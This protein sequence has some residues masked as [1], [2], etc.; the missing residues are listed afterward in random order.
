MS[1]ASIHALLRRGGVLQG[2][3]LIAAILVGVLLIF[4]LS[5]PSPAAADYKNPVGH[6]QPVHDLGGK[7]IVQEATTSQIREKDADTVSDKFFN[8]LGHHR[9]P[10]APETTEAAIIEAPP[11]PV[12]SIPLE[13][14]S[15]SL[16]DPVCA[17]FSKGTKDLLVVIKTPASELYNQLPT[18]F[19]T[20]LRCAPM[21]LWSYVSHKIGS[22]VIHD[23]LANV[24]VK[25]RQAN[26][27]FDLYHRLQTAQNAF[28]DFSTI[29]EDTDHNLDR[30]SIIPS[31]V[32]SYRMNPEKKWFVYIEGDTYLSLPNLLAW[33]GQLD[34]TIPFYAGA[35]TMLGDVELGSSSSGIVLSN[36]AM[37]NLA[38]LFEKRKAAWE[39]LSGKRCCG[40]QILAEALNE[41]NVTLTRSWPNT[42]GESPLS[43][44]WSSRH[45]CK[46]AVTW[47][48]I[49]P[50]LMDMLWQFERNWT[51]HHN[52]EAV[53]ANEAAIPLSTS[54]TRGWF[55]REAT[56][57]SS[58]SSTTSASP[59]PTAVKMEDFTKSIGI[60]PILYKDYFEGFIVSLVAKSQNRTDWDNL[61]QSHVYTDTS[62]TSSYAH[63]SPE[64]CRAACDIRSKCVQYVHE[65]N[66]CR[67]GTTFRMGEAVPADRRMKSGWLPHRVKKFGQSLGTCEKEFPFAMPEPI[68]PES[69]RKPEPAPPVEQPKEVVEED[70]FDEST[71]TPAPGSEAASQA[72]A[73]KSQT[74]QAQSAQ[75]PAAEGA[76]GEANMP[77]EA[78]QQPPS[79]PPPV[80][81]PEQELT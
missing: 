25:A 51:I 72:E 1:A 10:A 6:Q 45:W 23:A 80:P 18:R 4:Y 54:T 8:Y 31:L 9:D 75:P 7:D 40:D 69:E 58:A 22:Y 74:E 32:E 2:P 66:K 52:N 35:Q 73:A 70:E 20:N 55:K 42:Q 33:I 62:R 68:K 61:S 27:D 3:R 81:Q 16:G 46:A 39:I 56:A 76:K 36:A 64:T 21:I 65:P 15:D 59:S 63:S 29:V 50:P 71:E 11:V 53:A 79:E 49:T 43:I 28:Q 78:Q 44:D 38:T 37:K 48:R 19:L 30:W 26:R 41:A 34:H 12:S 60:P 24:T 77:E 47:H 13:F 5:A 67:I 14:D 57:T 17:V